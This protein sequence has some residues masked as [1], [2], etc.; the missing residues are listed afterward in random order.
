MK[1]FQAIHV[2]GLETTP[3]SGGEGGIWPFISQNFDVSVDSFPIHQAKLKFKHKCQ[4]TSIF[5]KSHCSFQ[6]LYVTILF[7]DFIAI[8]LSGTANL[9]L[10]TNFTFLFLFIT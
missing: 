2:Q 8:A 6:T 7:P 5:K 4:D 3:A 9:D 1:G 10:S